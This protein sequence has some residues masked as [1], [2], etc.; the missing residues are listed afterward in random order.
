MHEP[1]LY[2]SMTETIVIRP[3]VV[4]IVQDDWYSYLSDWDP[5]VVGIVPDRFQVASD[6]YRVIPEQWDERLKSGK[7]ET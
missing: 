7:D 2:E 3:F 5:R 4:S 1:W 6:R